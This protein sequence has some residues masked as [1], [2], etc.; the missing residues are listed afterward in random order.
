LLTAIFLLVSATGM[1]FEAGP[2][3]FM[4]GVTLI[5]LWS[6]VAYHEALI[7]LLEGSSTKKRRR[8]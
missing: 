3:A 7:F 5:L 8:N 1:L 2:G 4:V 6:G